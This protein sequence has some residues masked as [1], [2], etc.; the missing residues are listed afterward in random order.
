GEFWE[1]LVDTWRER[2]TAAGLDG[3]V[4]LRPGYVADNAVGDL[5]AAHH[6][7]VAPYRSA[8][9]SAVVPVASAAGR[10]TVA[11]PVGGLVEQVRDGQNGVLA[12]DGD[13]AAFA[14]AV[15]RALDNLD[16]LAAS[17]AHTAPTWDAV[18]GVV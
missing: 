11:T 5:L 2:V 12:A 13:A 6:L 1:P 14:D 4:D 8:T 3:A 18:A 7:V 17:A 15:T 10:P 9:Q 16:A